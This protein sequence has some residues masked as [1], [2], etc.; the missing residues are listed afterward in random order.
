MAH[1]KRRTS[2]ARQRK[3][4]THQ[5]LA[6]P[7]LAICPVTGERHL[8]HRAFWKEGRLYYRGKVLI[9]AP[10]KRAVSAS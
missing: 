2:K 5:K 8:P 4:R 3:R 6:T 10:K 7:Q 9:E 1:P